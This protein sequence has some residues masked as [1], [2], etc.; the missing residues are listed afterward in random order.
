MLASLSMLM[1]AGCTP[2]T[3]P[4]PS[5]PPPIPEVRF[6]DRAAE[7]GLAFRFRIAGPRPL[8]ILQSIGSGCAFLDFDSDGNLDILLVGERPGLF[9]GDGTGHFTDV[10]AL[11]RG[12][13]GHFLGCAVGDYDG[14]GFV[15]LYLSG[16]HEGRLLH[17]KAGKGFRDVTAASGLKPQPWGTACAWTDMNA[18]GKQDLIVGNY[19]AF[20]PKRDKR[21]CPVNGHP[22]GCGPTDYRPVKSVLYQNL[23]GGHFQGLTINGTQGGVLGCVVLP[24]EGSPRPAIA[25]INDERP[26]DL[27]TPTASGYQDS[28]PESGM[29]VTPEGGVYG[30][31]GVDSGDYDNDGDPDLIIATFQNEMN[32]LFQNQGSGLFANDSVRSGIALPAQHKPQVAFGVKFLDADNDGWLDVLFT[33]GHIRDNVETFDT[34]TTYRQ[35]TELFHNRHG[36]FAYQ[37][38]SAPIVGRGLAVGDYDNDGLPDA[39]AVDAEGAPLLLHNESTQTGNWLGISG[40]REG[41]KLVAQIGERTR[42]R[43]C[44]TDGSY[45]TASD[46]RVLFGLG[47]ATRVDSLTLTWPGGKTQTLKNLAP[48]HYVTAKETR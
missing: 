47:T 19:V 17:N 41:T 24:H 30:G 20:D 38:I 12:V 23:G 14:D 39:L 34:T 36:K 15:D 35:P 3:P 27:L 2:K 1:L 25:L 37:R 45:L 26:A 16:Y 9:R 48:N 18:D 7:A 32:N 21:L 29:A 4:A 13:H 22:T 10:T 40:L 28:G 8:D 46:A 31:M 42:T 33:N 5:P 11:L 44:H 6:V 43:W